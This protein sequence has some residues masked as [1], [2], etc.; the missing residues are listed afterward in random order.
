MRVLWLFGPPGVGKS[1]TAWQALNALS[2]DG[3]ETAY[4]DIDQL[5]M[6]YPA[7]DDDPYAERLA[8]HALAAVAGEFERQGAEWLVVSGVLNPDLMP[9]Y[10]DLMAPFDLTM[11]RLTVDLAEHKARMDARGVDSAGWDEVLEDRDAYE[12]A[13]LETP[14]V[15]AGGAPPDEIAR[16]VIAATAGAPNDREHPARGR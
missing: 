12:A 15:V 14:V 6:V 16:R 1:T 13:S 3:A 11:I 2:R 7:P 10:I 5:G 4:V 9:F 8:G